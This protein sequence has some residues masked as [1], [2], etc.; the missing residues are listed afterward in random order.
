MKTI[1]NKKK[2]NLTME[3]L[4]PDLQMVAD[5]CSLEIV[6]E[7]LENCSGTN[8]YLPKISK[9]PEFIC[10]YMKENPEKQVKEIAL[11]LGVSEPFIR[12]L[13]Y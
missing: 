1:E 5:R 8:L 11:E 7:L 4:T 6:N 9:F 10:R 3:E 13:Q 2:F 12:K